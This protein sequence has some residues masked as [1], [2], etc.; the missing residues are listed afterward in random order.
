MFLDL[1]HFKDV[2]DTLGH[3]AGDLLL[4]HVAESL[5]SCV[6]NDDIVCRWGGDEFLILFPGLGMSTN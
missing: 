4:R 2:N 3:D 6:R 5:S 1:D